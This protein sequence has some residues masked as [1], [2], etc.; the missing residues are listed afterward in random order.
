M[1]P[2][3]EGGVPKSRRVTEHPSPEPAATAFV[4]VRRLCP[5]SEKHCAASRVANGSISVLRLGGSVSETYPT[6]ISGLHPL[7]GR[8]NG[9][10]EVPF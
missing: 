3:T 6:P 10:L 8:A 5:V 9:S 7:S 4:R 2:T 1:R